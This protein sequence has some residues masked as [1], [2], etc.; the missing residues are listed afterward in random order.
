MKKLSF[1]VMYRAFLGCHWIDSGQISSVI[2][3]M[4]KMGFTWQ[5]SSLVQF[6]RQ[7]NARMVI[8]GRIPH[9]PT[10]EQEID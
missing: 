9:G 8:S 10:D 6:S 1:W 4:C 7:V 3:A 2:Q 5:V